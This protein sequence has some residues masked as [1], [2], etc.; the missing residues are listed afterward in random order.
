MFACV[1]SAR[2]FKPSQYQT[3]RMGRHRKYTGVRSDETELLND[4]NTV[5]SRVGTISNTRKVVF[6][7]LVSSTRVTTKRTHDD[8]FGD[9]WEPSTMEDDNIDQPIV[10]YS[11]PNGRK[12]YTSSVSQVSLSEGC[13]SP[14]FRH[15]LYAFGQAIRKEESLIPAIPRNTSMSLYNWKGAVCIESWLRVLIVMWRV[16]NFCTGAKIALV[17]DWSARIASFRVIGTFP[18]I[19]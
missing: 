17:L 12:K 9:D 19:G 10:V 6:K 1:S 13:Y 3:L 4:F 18:V 14:S 11:V 15:V 8:A 16:R 2:D 7:A 5:Q